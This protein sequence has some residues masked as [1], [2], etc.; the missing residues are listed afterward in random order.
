MAERSAASRLMTNSRWNVASFSVALITNFLTIPLAIAAIGLDQFGSAGLVL[1]LLAPPTL[2]GTV[3]GQVLVR[4]L[5]RAGALADVLMARRIFWSA[6]SWC[7]VGALAIGLLV[8]AWGP[9][10]MG[11]LSRGQVSLTNWSAPLA[12]GFSA[13]LLQQFC[14]LAQATLAARQAY[15]NLAVAN[16]VGALMSAFAVVS[17]SR[18]WG[19]G[20]GFLAGTAL[21]F[22]LQ[23]LL[24]ILFV[25]LEFPALLRPSLWSRAESEPILRFVRWQGVAHFAGS[26]ANQADRYVLGAVAPLAVVGQYNVAMRLQEVVHMGV[27]KFSEVL[28]PHFCATA[29][30]LSSTRA[31]FFL[32]AS[33]TISLIGAA[34]LAPLIP[35]AN[36]LITLWV[37][38]GAA[39]YGGPILRILATA[40][41]V[42][43]SIHVFSFF[44]MATGQTERLAYINL[45]HSGLM[46]TLT[47]L[48]IFLL[49][50]VAAGLAY[51]ICNLIRWC[52]ANW[53]TQR[54][55]GG[56]ISSLSLMRASAI[57]IVCGL[58][59]GWC[60]EVTW[61]PR[62]DDWTTLLA[63]YL[64]CSLAVLCVGMVLTAASSEGR[65]WL[66]DLRRILMHRH[67]IGRL[68]A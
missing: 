16:A 56:A 1:G 40:G 30:Q 59:A 47:V 54:H 11:Y 62:A 67:A 46:V 52:L 21:G 60:L 9:W 50:P 42:G 68:K 33:W 49:G 14:F 13:W 66:R 18:I 63:W 45:L 22:G 15:R 17:L 48:L 19:D 25:A 55:F 51:V 44:A 31:R 3:L 4:D 37:G 64:A 28:Y 27:L 38:A 61:P 12:A 7:A 57:P 35:L 2:I 6:I 10:A 53:I 65:D 23:L 29:D 41:V 58:S 8:A 20:F 32:R 43:C 36:P 26:L 24:L 34:A 5:A 39:T